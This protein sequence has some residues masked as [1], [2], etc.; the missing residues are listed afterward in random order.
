MRLFF[1]G[2][3]FKLAKIGVV[4]ALLVGLAMSALQMYIDFRLQ[5]TEIDQLITRI[6]SVSTPPAAR[7]VHILDDRLASEV[8]SGLMNYSFV[9]SV[10]IEDELGNQ[11]AAASKERQMSSTLWLTKVLGEELKAFASPLHIPG[12]QGVS[13]RL[14]FVVD[15]D[16]AYLPFYRSSAVLISLGLIRSFFLV[17]F[18]FIAFYF[19]LT[20]P[21][22]KIAN[23]LK[24]INPGSPGEQRVDLPSHWNKQD[25]L[26]QIVNSAN[27]LL[28]A[29][30]LALA[31]RKSVEGVLRK[32][33]EH[34]R[35]II[36]SL[37]V[38]VGARNKEGYYIFANRALASF[39]NTTPDAIRG[40]HISEFSNFFLSSTDRTLELDSKVIHTG[41]NSH[42]WEE[43]WRALDGSERNMHTY[44]MPL[45]FYDETVA[46]VVSSDITDLKSA[47]QL[48]E[49]MAYHDALTDLPNRSYLT[50]R[51]EE[52]LTRAAKQGH[53]G[54]LLFIDLDQF[55]NINDSLGHP[56]GDKILRSVASRLISVTD[57]DD[58]VVRLGGDE[59][60]VV[61][62]KLGRRAFRI[63]STRRRS[64]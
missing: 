63:D 6:V 61:L 59:F 27:Q 5:S 7:S 46:L 38:W 8:V 20:K 24:S 17:F 48:M 49:H 23:E 31:K 51:L 62:P 43:T 53:Y 33:E 2:I 44:V 26:H 9:I 29:I 1:Q 42:V 58:V 4:I 35:Q 10:A 36:D 39:L 37:P 34:I 3:S 16:S 40:S 54:A 18:L 21:L 15:M 55:K 25:E 45:E 50:E 32:S 56:A 11:L 19:L 64:W 14:S 60:V 28:E 22:V 41:T 13:G 12:Q 57:V 30:G 52:E 47:Q